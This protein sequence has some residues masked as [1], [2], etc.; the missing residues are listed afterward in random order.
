MILKTIKYIHGN[1]SSGYKSNSII[2]LLKIIRGLEFIKKRIFVKDAII[3]RNK[4]WQ[5]SK[6][7]FGGDERKTVVED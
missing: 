3:L 1:D 4:W 2:W 5:I 7:D 6:Y